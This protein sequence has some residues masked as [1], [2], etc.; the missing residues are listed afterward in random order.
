MKKNKQI[1]PLVV[2]KTYALTPHLQRIEFSFDNTAPFPLNSTGQYIKL[3]FTAQGSTDLNLLNEQEQ[4]ILRTYTIQ[5]ADPVTHTI[6]VDFVKHQPAS[7]TTVLSPVNGGYAQHFAHH[8]RVGDTVSMLGPNPIKPLSLN[9]DKLLLVADLSSLAALSAQI[10]SLPSNAKGHVVIELLSEEDRPNIL[11]PT[12]MSLSLCIRGEAPSLV[13]T[14]KNLSG[15]E[16]TLSVWCACEFNDMKAIR[17]YVTDNTSLVQSECY[18]SSYWK[19][20]TTEDGHKIA[21]RADQNAF[22]H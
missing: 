10:N 1:Q 2:R 6:T 4:P 16:G 8:A 19:E 5:N 22:V 3:L 17:R 7:A 12:A 14:V 13:S 21:K 20:G 11:L 18:F 15:L 9:T